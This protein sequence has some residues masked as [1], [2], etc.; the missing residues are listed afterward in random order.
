[1]YQYT[2]NNIIV[3]LYE[4]VFSGSVFVL[5]FFSSPLSNELSNT[6]HR[7]SSPPAPKFLSVTCFTKICYVLPASGHVISCVF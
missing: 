1:M 5:R 6:L 4:I 2:V 7:I 3:A